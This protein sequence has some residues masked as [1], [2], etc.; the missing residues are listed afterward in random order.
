MRLL[1]TLLKIF[2]YTA[3]AVASDIHD[4]DLG[5]LGPPDATSVRTVRLVLLRQ[6]A[7][8]VLPLWPTRRKDS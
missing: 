3:P 2:L 8:K 6:R 4:Q 5:P 7:A 1:P